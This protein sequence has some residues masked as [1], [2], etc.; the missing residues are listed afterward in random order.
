MLAGWLYEAAPLFERL[1]QEQVLLVRITLPPGAALSTPPS[2]A[3]IETPA[4]TTVTA[5]LVSPAP[6]TDQR[7]QGL[8]FFYRTGSSAGL[9][10]GM[11]VSARLAAGPK[12]KG[13]MILPTR[14]VVWWHEHRWA[15]VRTT[16]D[17]F[18]RQAVRGGFPV[19]DGWFVRRGFA[20]GQ[21]IAVMGT[22][23]LLSQEFQSLIQGGD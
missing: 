16:A 4:G 15:Y 14:A 18:K 17:R 20:S 22:Q 1:M 13:V 19:P 3:L 11:N 2:T 5:S 9:L 6:D 21:R 10:P 23:L 12:L 7:I 8:S